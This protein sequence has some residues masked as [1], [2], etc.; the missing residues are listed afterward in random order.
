MWGGTHAY[1]AACYVCICYMKFMS[2][3]KVL[4]YSYMSM[5]YKVRRRENSAE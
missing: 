2:L 5:L 1:A 3:R 4:I